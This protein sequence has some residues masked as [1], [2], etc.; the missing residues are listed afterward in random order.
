[1]GP[2]R[3]LQYFE[4]REAAIERELDD[5]FNFGAE[6]PQWKLADEQLKI[7]GELCVLAEIEVRRALGRRRELSRQRALIQTVL[8]G[9]SLQPAKTPSLTSKLWFTIFYQ[10]SLRTLEGHERIMFRIQLRTDSLPRACSTKQKSG[11]ISEL[12]PRHF[13]GRGRRMRMP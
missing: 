13:D 8:F 9:V 1:M 6:F 5:P 10:R 7:A 12:E 4:R 3:L 2:E 11:S